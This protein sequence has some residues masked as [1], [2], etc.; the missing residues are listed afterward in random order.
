MKKFNRPVTIV[1]ADDHELFRDGLS[2]IL[3]KE[4]DIN[5]VGIAANG[6]ELVELVK[7][8]KP[9]VVLTDIVMPGIDG[10]EATKQIL[11]TAPATEVVALSM[12]DD[13]SLI[14]DILDAGATGYLLKNADKAEIVE[15]V[16]TAAK[17]EQYYSKTISIKLAKFVASNRIRKQPAPAFTENELEVIRYI[18][19]EFT[20]REIGEQLHL[21][22]RTIHGYRSEIL[23]KINV[24]S[25]AGIVIY[26]IQHNLYTP[27]SAKE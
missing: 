5:I 7:Q 21:S 23:R 16:Y 3:A 15:A 18:C 17:H 4:P 6:L 12:F 1:I 19:K 22:K 26:A 24:R 13:E 2:L 8:H 9:A 10:I 14:V 27:D 20:T 25:T 11:Q